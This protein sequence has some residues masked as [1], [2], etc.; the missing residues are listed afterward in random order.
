SIRLPE[1]ERILASLVSRVP[2]RKAGRFQRRFMELA[3][4]HFHKRA[5]LRNGKEA[6]RVCASGTK[7]GDA[8]LCCVGV[9]FGMG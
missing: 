8:E 2:A 1:A 7:L 3:S 6:E 4:G 9:E 5:F